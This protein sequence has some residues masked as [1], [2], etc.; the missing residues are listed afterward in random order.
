MIQFILKIIKLFNEHSTAIIAIATIVG[1]FLVIPQINEFNEQNEL[2]RR[3]LLQSYRPIG[4]ITQINKPNTDIR[5]IGLPPEGKKDKFTFTY[6]QSLI[7]EGSGLLVN[8]GHLYFISKERVDFRK[9]FLNHDYD[10]TEIRFDGRWDYTRR[11]TVLPKDTG[12]V[13]VRF[14]DISFED[15]YNIYILF[16]YEDQDGNVYDTENKINLTFNPT[17][18]ENERVRAHLR[19]LST[20]NFYNAYSNSQALE[21]LDLLKGYNHPLW[22]YFTIKE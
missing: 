8:I 12:L 21:L 1:L 6:D 17:T 20:N 22:K 2:L 3:T 11:T 13:V 10:S 4:Y 15:E 16:F 18:I 5:V 19:T 9:K 7:N 14:N